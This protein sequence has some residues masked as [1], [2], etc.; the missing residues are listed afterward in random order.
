MLLL[1]FFDRNTGLSFEIKQKVTGQAGADYLK[2]IEIMGS[3]K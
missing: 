2:D 1:T 3:L